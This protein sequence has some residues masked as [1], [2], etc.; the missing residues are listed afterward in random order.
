MTKAAGER[1]VFAWTA[2]KSGQLL[3][4]QSWQNKQLI[5]YQC[6]QITIFQSPNYGSYTLK[7]YCI[8]MCFVIIIKILYP[9]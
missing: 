7:V 3:A 8:Q 4:G 5:F 1:R 2:A 9:S 6:H